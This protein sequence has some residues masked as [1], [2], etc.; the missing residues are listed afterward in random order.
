M[1][2]GQMGSW[3]GAHEVGTRGLITSGKKGL[4]YFDATRPPGAAAA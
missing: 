4:E 2:N 1:M 3:D